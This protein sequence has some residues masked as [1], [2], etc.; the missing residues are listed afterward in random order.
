TVD[1][2]SE[3]YEVTVDV[4]HMGGDDTVEIL[5]RT[6]VTESGYDETVITDW[7]LTLNTLEFEIAPGYGRNEVIITL[8]NDCGTVSETIEIYKDCPAQDPGLTAIFTMCQGCYNTLPAIGFLD[9]TPD[10]GGVW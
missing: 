10:S 7:D 4:R 6:N 2:E 8:T 5:H 9:G 1:D 3:P